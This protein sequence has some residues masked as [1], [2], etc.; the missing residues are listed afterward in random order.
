MKKHS[1]L[2]CIIISLIFLL[3][4][5]SLYPGGSIDDLDSA[6]FIW[7][8]NFFSNLFTEK[9]LN[10][11]PNPSR[12]WALTGMAFHSIAY[13]LFF[14]HS[15]SKIPQKHA[16]YVLKFVGI[17]N[18]LFT[19]LIAT[20]LHDYMITISSTLSLLGLFYLTVF[21]LKTKLQF[22]KAFS[23]GSLL[24]FY[25]TLYLYGAGDRGLLAVMQK[26]AFFCFTLLILIIEYFT[27]SADFQYKKTEKPEI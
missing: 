21:I 22:L 15:S 17:S 5:T 10:G 18:M 12:L 3:I 13:G 25:Y 7:S 4:A 14:V 20:P 16:A 26:I 27:K 1:V 8:K 2:I 23:I 24:L 9:A 6:G 11:D 19:F